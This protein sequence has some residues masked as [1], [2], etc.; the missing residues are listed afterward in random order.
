MSQWT[1]RPATIDDL[2][3]IVQFNLRLASESEDK[4][5]PIDRLRRGVSEILTNPARGRYFVALDG[6]RIVGQLSYTTEWSDWR[7][8]EIW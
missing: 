3:A 8:G 2:D 6:G 5:L 1:V 4:T 7:N